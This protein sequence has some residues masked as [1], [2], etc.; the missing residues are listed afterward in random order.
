MRRLD[1]HVRSNRRSWHLLVSYQWLGELSLPSQ[2]TNSGSLPS[3]NRSPQIGRLFQQMISDFA[4]NSPANNSAF[5]PSLT[6]WT[7]FVSDV[8]LRPF[9]RE[10][11]R[12]GMPLWFR[13]LL[14]KLPCA[15]PDYSFRRSFCGTVVVWPNVFPSLG[16]SAWAFRQIQDKLRAILKW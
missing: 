12:L 13:P 15:L 16:N 11:H 1:R 6:P 7:I 4:F 14:Q 8:K 10:K 3:I 9:R 2:K 5:V